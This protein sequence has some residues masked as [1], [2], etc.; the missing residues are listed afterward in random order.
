M[1]LHDES[2]NIYEMLQYTF[3]NTTDLGDWNNMI[4]GMVNVRNLNEIG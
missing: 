2:G 3:F 1:G 4:N